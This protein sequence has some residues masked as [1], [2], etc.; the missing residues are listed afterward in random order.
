MRYI[1]KIICK[2]SSLG[3][4]LTEMAI[5]TMITG[6]LAAGG[7]SFAEFNSEKNKIDQLN[8]QLDE[9]EEAIQ[10]YVDVNYKVPFPAGPTAPPN[11]VEFGKERTI[12][13]ADEV[14]MYTQWFRKVSW[15]GVVPVRA[16]GLPDEHMFDPWG[17]RIS[18]AITDFTQTWG[19]LNQYGGND[20]RYNYPIYDYDANV[21]SYESVLK[22]LDAAGNQINPVYQQIPATV[23][24]TLVSHGK[25]GVGAY[26]RNGVRT[27]ACTGTTLEIENCNQDNFF[28]IAD[29][30]Y[31]SSSNNY[32][33]D[34][35]RWKN[36]WRLA[37][38]TKGNYLGRSL[39]YAKFYT[40]VA[41]STYLACSPYINVAQKFNKFTN[42][43]LD[44]AGLA[45]GSARIP[46]G[47][48]ALMAY[49]NNHLVANE[50]Y[51]TAVNWVGNATTGRIEMGT[52]R[53]T[54]LADMKVATFNDYGTAYV[55][56]ETF[57]CGGAAGSY[58]GFIT[59]EP[60]SLEIF[61]LFE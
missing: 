38:M 33:D 10:R 57:E 58:L 43:N 44:T 51:W 14:V 47:Q 8:K 11:S 23:A 32:F 29:H 39:G 30:N 34:Y 6:L 56:R 52:D 35:V 54:H 12:N 53:Q 45:S 2:C 13:G 4:S 48:Y 28:R 25:R 36:H 50:R 61:K 46:P 26:N 19:G 9:I 41:N 60:V 5:A 7:M 42:L 49:T 3:Y 17:N 40:D 21:Y 24:Y 31:D 27:I 20:I 37:S 1:E 59:P 55:A 15:H 16:L 18:Y 22:I